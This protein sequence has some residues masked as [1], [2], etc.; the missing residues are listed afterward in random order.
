MV[1]FRVQIKLA[2]RP[3]CQ[4]LSYARDSPLPREDVLACTK[5]VKRYNNQGVPL[6]FDVNVGTISQEMYHRHMH[7]FF[8]VVAAKGTSTCGRLVMEV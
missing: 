4:T 6:K 7:A 3:D 2:T 1:S 5:I 8:R